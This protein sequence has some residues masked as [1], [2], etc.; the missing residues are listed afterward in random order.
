[1]NPEVFVSY[2]GVISHARVVTPERIHEDTTLRCE[3]G[4]IVSIGGPIDTD[5]FDA[6]GRLLVPGFLDLHCH[7]GGGGSFT[8]GDRSSAEQAATFH[9]LHGTTTLVASTVSSSPATL[10]RACKTLGALANE[11]LLAGIHLEG[12]Y[13]SA[14]RCGAQNPAHLRPPSVEELQHLVEV[15]GHNVVQVTL[16]PELDGAMNAIRWLVKE[17]IIV[18]IGHSDANA[19]TVEQAIDAGAS[20]ATHLCNAMTPLHHRDPTAALA[21]LDDER[22]VIEVINDGV[23][24]LPATVRLIAARAGRKRLAFITDAISAAGQGDGTYELGDLSVCIVGG[25]ARL[26]TSDSHDGAIAGSTLT[27]DVAFQRA[28]TLGLDPVDVARATA[29]VAAELLGLGDRGTIEVGKR[30]DFVLLPEQ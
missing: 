14:H 28:L 19:E 2:S 15:S 12:P 22:V 30:A 18:A 26:K 1:M 9:R 6:G 5:A 29:T 7:G 4:S 11:G 3:R 25:V 16:A 27:M 13:L 8:T 23:H 21:L 17:G 24:L 20:L 10:L